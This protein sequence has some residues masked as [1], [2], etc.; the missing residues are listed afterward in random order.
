MIEAKE[1]ELDN[2]NMEASLDLGS[3]GREQLQLALGRVS[4]VLGRNK[5]FAR[6]SLPRLINGQLGV[7]QSTMLNIQRSAV[8][9]NVVELH[10]VRK[11]YPIFD[12]DGALAI[13]AVSWV[14]I[15]HFKAQ[16]PLNIPWVRIIEETKELLGENPISTKLSPPQ[17]RQSMLL[18]TV[19][20][21]QFFYGRTNK[22]K[23]AAAGA[24]ENRK[25]SPRQAVEEAGRLDLD[26]LQVL[27][28]SLSSSID[29]YKFNGF[30][31]DFNV[32]RIGRISDFCRGITR[33]REVE[34]IEECSLKGQVYDCI[35]YMR[36]LGVG[37]LIDLEREVRRRVLLSESGSRLE[38]QFKK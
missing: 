11:G 13:S 6:E 25:F 22:L 29:Y 27:H 35:K 20:S 23:E 18:I 15:E 17:D 24:A 3:A 10:A 14:V 12:T 38:L 28:E 32:R 1:L 34:D 16:Q 37:N 2:Q 8:S 7:S 36:L 9:Q 26:K 31:S 21:Q 4:A 33:Q 19:S 5:S 30:V